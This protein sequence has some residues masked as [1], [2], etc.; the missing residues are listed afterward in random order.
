M[1]NKSRQAR[2]DGTIVFAV[3]EA[4]D[5]RPLTGGIAFEF[6]YLSSA[7]TSQSLPVAGTLVGDYSTNH[8]NFVAFTLS[9]RF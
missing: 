4:I 5:S 6:L 8:V 7:P 1:R 2:L 9:K 3:T